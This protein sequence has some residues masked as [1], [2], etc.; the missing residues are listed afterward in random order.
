MDEHKQMT[1]LPALLGL[2]LAISVADR[3]PNFD[4]DPSCRRA[5]SGSIGLRQD[6]RVCRLDENAARDQLANK[7]SEF[8][9]ADRQSCTTLESSGGDPTYTELI[10]CLEMARDARRLPSE[11][12]I[13]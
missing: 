10:T 12:A 3:I 6:L 2:Q 8:S 1:L 4:I 13:P 9:F 5:A 7:W 11:A